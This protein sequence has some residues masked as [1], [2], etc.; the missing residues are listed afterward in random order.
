MSDNDTTL[1]FPGFPPIRGVGPAIT[2]V[3]G[4]TLNA[5]ATPYVVYPDCPESAECDYC[6]EYAEYAA[7]HTHEYFESRDGA[8]SHTADELA[9][10]F[11][12]SVEFYAA[13]WRRPADCPRDVSGWLDDPDDS[14]AL[15]DCI[16]LGESALS[17][18]GLSVY[19]DDGYIIERVTE[20]ND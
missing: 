14:Q 4:P 5:E 8:A 17:D 12:D 6:E 9:D 19:W 3:T 13:P 16:A 2:E 10:I 7:G 15:S 18:V 11:L 20:H 1:N